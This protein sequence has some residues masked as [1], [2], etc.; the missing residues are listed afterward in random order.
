MIDVLK[1]VREMPQSA[2][3]QKLCPQ[4]APLQKLCPQLDS[5][6]GAPVLCVGGRLRAAHQIAGVSSLIILPPKH[7]ITE[8]IVRQ[9]DDKCNHGVGTNHLLSQYL[10]T[11]TGLFVENRWPKRTVT[12]A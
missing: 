10:W 5:T 9:E 6:L 11:N 1:S 2:P 7:R 3:L 4:S 8:L 12:H